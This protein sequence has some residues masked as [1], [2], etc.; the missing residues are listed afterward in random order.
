MADGH[1][2]P[3]WGKV[4]MGRGDGAPELVKEIGG[5]I[6]FGFSS[7]LGSGSKRDAGSISQHAHLGTNH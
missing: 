6:G 4:R 2:Q 5:V 1:K 7:Q 3:M